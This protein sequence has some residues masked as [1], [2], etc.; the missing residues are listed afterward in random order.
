MLWDFRVVCLMPPAT[1]GSR[2]PATCHEVTVISGSPDPAHVVMPRVHKVAALLKR[3]IMGTLQGGIQHQLH[4]DYYLDKF[5]S[6]FNRRR[7]RKSAGSCST[8]SPNRPW[9][10][11][12]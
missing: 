12:R 2:T 4:L 5:T 9:T 8:A 11:S 6:R 10:S 1:T 7:S 3:W